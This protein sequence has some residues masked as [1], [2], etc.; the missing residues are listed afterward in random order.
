MLIFVTTSYQSSVK[1]SKMFSQMGNHCTKLIRRS[2]I[3]L[4]YLTASSFEPIFIFDPIFVF[5]FRD[6][7]NANYQHF[8]DYKNAKKNHN[9]FDDKISVICSFM[10]PVFLCSFPHLSLVSFMIVCLFYFENIGDFVCQK[11]DWWH[12]LFE[13][14]SFLLFSY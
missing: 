7:R 13:H 2:Y 12:S 4:D 3:F 6:Y 11:I 5:I 10:H 1:T 9:L 8:R 14:L